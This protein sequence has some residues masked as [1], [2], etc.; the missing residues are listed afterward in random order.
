MC[1]LP[2]A[3]TEL[4]AIFDGDDSPFIPRG[5]SQIGYVRTHESPKC[6]HFP[7]R[8][9]DEPGYH[10]QGVPVGRF[11]WR[12]SPSV[13]VSEWHYRGGRQRFQSASFVRRYSLECEQLL[14]LGKFQSGHV[15]Q[16][17][18]LVVQP[19]GCYHFHCE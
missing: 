9:L 1:L 2:E 18:L 13:P 6:W 15:P 14:A 4:S 17:R 8:F 19:A 7:S 12:S 10:V 5:P 3:V 11:R 16:I